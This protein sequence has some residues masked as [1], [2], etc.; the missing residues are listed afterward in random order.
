[1]GKQS[2]K[3]FWKNSKPSTG[4]K[5]QIIVIFDKNSGEFDIKLNFEDF[6]LAE[7]MLIDALVRMY[8][9]RKGKEKG[10]KRIIEAGSLIYLPGA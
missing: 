10:T 4:Y 7:G 1:V 8:R 9:S 2:A 6:D 3:P 5:H